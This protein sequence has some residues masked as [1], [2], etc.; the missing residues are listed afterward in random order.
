MR[1][2]RIG[3]A[4]IL[5]MVATGAHAADAGFDVRGAA[6]VAHYVQSGW[7]HPQFVTAE[8]VLGPH[9]GGF[10]VGGLGIRQIDG[11][12]TMIPLVTYVGQGVVP[13]LSFLRGV[14]ITFAMTN[15]GVLNGKP[16]YFFGVGVATK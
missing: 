16:A 11:F 14:T 5:A 1:Y 6:V 2:A 10:Y 15:Q 3:A 9:V 4:A 8:F 7:S 12:G 13:K